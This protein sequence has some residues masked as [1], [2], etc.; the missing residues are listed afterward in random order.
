MAD[1]PRHLVRTKALRPEEATHLR[2]PLNPKS[3]VRLHSLGDRAG[4]KRNQLHLARLAPGAESFVLHWHE[5]QEEF[6]FILEGTGRAT[7]G[8]AEVTV[9]PGDYVGF[10]C[11]GIAHHLRNDG[12]TDLVYLMGGERT[13]LEVSHFPSLGKTAVYD[14]SGGKFYDEKTMQALAYPDFVAKD[15]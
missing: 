2:H 12:T 10:P 15:R 11:D 13:A 6:V 14:A 4:M 9:G 1:E 8:D 7:I 3:D 5:L